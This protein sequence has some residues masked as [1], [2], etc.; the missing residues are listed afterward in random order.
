MFFASD[1][2]SDPS[3]S[4]SIAFLKRG[5][6]DRRL[7][8]DCLLAADGLRLNFLTGV[9]PKDDT[10]QTD[11]WAP[12]VDGVDLVEP[13]ERSVARGRLAAGVDLLLGTNLDEGTEFMSLTPPL[14]CN[15]TPADLRAWARAFYGPAV[16][17]RLEALYNSSSLE[18]PLP[19]CGPGGS[20]A[21]VPG[22][23]ALPYNVAMR[24]AGDAAIRCPTQLLAEVAKGKSFV[25]RFSVTPDFSVNFGNTTVMGAFHGAEVPFVFGDDFELSSGHERR[26]SAAMGCYWRSFAWHGDPGV[27]A[28]GGV[29]WPQYSDEGH[30]VLE[31]GASVDV[32]FEEKVSRS[33][34][35]LFSKR[36]AAETVEIV[37]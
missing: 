4:S 36:G 17:A 33:R 1:V 25:Y 30:P 22:E 5:P 3:M 20:P 24:S 27:E 15:A 21:D 23:Q 18:R 11:A 35:D 10:F 29:A 6:Q 9:M 19:A 32:Q 7:R 16:G 28:C 12:V 34:C 2:E 37:V 26:V 31:L 14:R 8:L 13:I